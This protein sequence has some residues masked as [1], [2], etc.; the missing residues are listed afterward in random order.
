MGDV[1]FDVGG[2]HLFVVGEAFLKESLVEA[3]GGI[4]VVGEYFA[5]GFG[6]VGNEK[7]DIFS[8]LWLEKGGEV[9]AIFAGFIVLITLARRL[10]RLFF[11]H[12]EKANGRNADQI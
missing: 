1:A 8:F 11:S 7:G 10:L 12:I 5:H 4:E 3:G 2:H 9:F 6:T